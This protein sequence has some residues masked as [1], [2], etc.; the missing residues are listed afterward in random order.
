MSSIH[1]DSNRGQ[2]PSTPST[3]QATQ[4]QAPPEEYA[5]NDYMRVRITRVRREGP[6]VTDSIPDRVAGRM[7]RYYPHSREIHVSSTNGTGTFDL[8]VNDVEYVHIDL[9]GWLQKR[10][11]A[12]ARGTL[13][14]CWA[15]QPDPHEVA[16]EGE[17]FAWAYAESLHKAITLLLSASGA[18]HDHYRQGETFSLAEIITGCLG[19][20]S[21][22]TDEDAPAIRDVL[23]IAIAATFSQEARAARYEARQVGREEA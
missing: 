1:Q 22:L 18:A 19:D 21:E 15:K 11:Q 10:E 4:P 12:R 16:L 9:L 6:N 23:T 17:P 8:E 7:G 20:H 13:I 2:P 3:E 5:P 14:A